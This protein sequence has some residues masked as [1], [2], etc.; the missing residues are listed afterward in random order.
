MMADDFANEAA[1]FALVS[2]AQSELTSDRRHLLIE[3]TTVDHGCVRLALRL[4]DVRHFV[5][6]MLQ[7]VS[8][9]AETPETDGGDTLRQPIPLSAV[10]I[11]EFNDGDGFLTLTVGPTPLTFGGPPG[12][13]ARL[14]SMI[15]AAGAPTDR[16]H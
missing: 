5:T 3:A 8:Q 15:A 2:H 7:V 6:L 4:A 12:S 13:L 1:G 10:E 16:R 14:G 11:G 9:A